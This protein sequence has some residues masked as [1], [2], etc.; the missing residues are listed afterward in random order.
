M[1]YNPHTVIKPQ[2]IVDSAAALTAQSLVLSKLVTRKSVDVFK[3]R[4]GDKIVERVPGRLP[5]RRYAFRNNRANPIKFD[6]Y[7]E[8][9]AE[10][11]MGDHLY[12]GVAVTDEQRD[13]DGITWDK[14]IPMQAEAV[15]TGFE[16]E[17]ARMIETAPYEVVVGGVKEGTAR[18]ALLEAR[19]VLNR[20]R[21]PDQNRVLIVGSDFE[22]ML[23]EDRNLVFAS[24]G[25]DAVANR[26][27]VEATLGRLLGFTVVT[28]NTI[29]PD[30]AYAFA[31]SGFVA[32]SGAPSLPQNVKHGGT[33]V[34]DGVS[35][36]WLTDYDPD[37]MT[38]RSVV[39]M[40][41][42]TGV[43]LDRLAPAAW[44]TEAEPPVADPAELGELSQHFL[45]GVKISMSEPSKYPKAGT[46]VAKETGVSEA[47]AWKASAHDDTPTVL[48]D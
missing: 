46:N 42:G 6:V 11:T 2:E 35:L 20:F 7:K 37:Y 12:S 18:S 40:W 21:T 43:S 28:D 17:V 47:Q 30:A 19:K 24:A 34:Y 16:A 27:L 5:Y 48:N 22:Q 32:Y 41:C 44:Y 15:A 3:G 31:G 25:G 8:G 14:I 23:L 33:R 39:D 1:V 36:R 26:A 9:I 38:D 13:F 10:V 4:E 29:Q 45:R